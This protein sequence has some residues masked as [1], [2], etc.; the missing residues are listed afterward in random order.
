MFVPWWPCYILQAA[1]VLPVKAFRML[2]EVVTYP[3]SMHHIWNNVHLISLFSL[4]F[5]ITPLFFLTTI[6]SDYFIIFLYL[7]F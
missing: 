1:Y 2:H 4:N 6:I 5:F 7:L 3:I